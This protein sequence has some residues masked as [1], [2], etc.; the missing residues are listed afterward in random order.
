MFFKLKQVTHTHFY[1]TPSYS[2][3][4]TLIWFPSWRLVFKRTWS[5]KMYSDL[6]MIRPLLAQTINF[7]DFTFTFHFHALEKAMATHST[8]LA[9]R[10]PGKGEP[11][12]LPSMGSHRVG[13]DW[14]DSAAAAANCYYKFPWTDIHLSL[15][16]ALE[17][18]PFFLNFLFCIWI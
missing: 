15:L 2:T 10:I 6:L 12:G 11:G 3:F 13:H 7:P 18:S 14:S 17:I 1:S 16:P 5:R 9:W 4:A 8:V